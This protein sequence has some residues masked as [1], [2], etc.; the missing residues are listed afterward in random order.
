MVLAIKNESSLQVVGKVFQY[1]LVE[2]R[3]EERVR[4]CL[5][6]KADKLVK[7]H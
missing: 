6:L 7:F 3:K 2:E 1:V 5:S 4:C